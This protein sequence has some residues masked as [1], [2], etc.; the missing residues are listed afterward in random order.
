MAANNKCSDCGAERELQYAN[1]SCCRNCRSARNKLVRVSKML[2]KGKR[3]QGSGRN[4]NCSKCGSLKDPSFLTSG[5]CRKCKSERNRANRLK[6]RLAR[7]QVPLGQ[8]RK[9]YCCDCGSL[10]EN[11]NQGYC[12]DCKA[13]NGRQNR[14]ENKKS[15]DFV[16]RERHKVNTRVK[17]D[18]LFKLK[19]DVHLFTNSAT[20]LGILIRQPCE[21]CGELK[22]DAHHD[23]YTKPMDVR[24][25][26][27]KHHN[28]HH[29]NNLT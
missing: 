22:V 13:K 20:R 1:D 23:D 10:K 2:A 16:I 17:N 5:Y 12:N 29:R 6:A 9:I 18:P 25:L 15:I 14:I 19:K 7:G 21:I 27:R 4:P 11:R 28:E 3:P 24:W 26:C 8:G